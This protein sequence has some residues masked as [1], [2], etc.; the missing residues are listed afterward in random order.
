MLLLLALLAPTIASASGRQGSG[1]E[2]DIPVMTVPELVR[3]WGYPVEEHWVT[4]E[5]GYI[6]GLHRI[7]HGRQGNNNIGP[8]PVAWLQHCLTCSSAIWTF[9]PPAKSLGLLLA[10]AGYDVWMG[11]SRGNTYSRN[12]TSLEPC[13][14]ERCADFW[15]F[16]WDEGGLYDVTAGIDFALQQTGETQVTYVGHSMGCTQ[17]L[18]MLSARPEYNAKVRLGVLLAPPAFMSHAPSLIFQLAKWAGDIQVLYH[19]FGFAE[20]LPH[21]DFIT[22]LGHLVCSDDHP[23]LQTVCMNIGFSILGFNPDQLN[24][25]MIPT[26]LDHIPEG[27]STRPFVHYAQLYMNGKFESYDYGESGNEE[28]YG[29]PGPVQYQL[30]RVT[31]PTAIFKSD[32]DDLAD[33]VDIDLLVNQLPNVVMDHMVE[34][35]GW[36]HTDYIVAMDADR[37]VYDYVLDLVRAH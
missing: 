14:G 36:T 1:E 3:Y 23:L 7:P 26:Y 19:L 27:T 18:V 20:F 33:L 31:A 10:D 17:Y 5:D 16:G 13:S 35:D 2:R 37:L 28:H 9:G 34:R 32:A 24:G 6:L 22:W 29:Q 25:T 8:R 15:Q 12:H 30:D 11:N 21:Y 4:T